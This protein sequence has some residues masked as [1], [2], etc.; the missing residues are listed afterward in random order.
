MAVALDFYESLEGMRVTLEDPVVVGPTMAQGEGVVLA[1]DGAGV[2]P[3]TA[4]GGVLLSP[5]DPNPERIVLDDDLLRGPTW[6]LMPEANVGDHFAAPC[7]TGIL[8]AGA[9]AY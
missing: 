2:S 1:S 5:D 7:C 3:R 9:G 6:P 8:I 4:R